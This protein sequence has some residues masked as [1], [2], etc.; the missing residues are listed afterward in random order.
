MGNSDSKLNFRKAVVQLTS[1]NQSIDLNDQQFWSQFWS[2][3]I[4][5]INDIYTLI[6]SYEIRALREESPSNLA[7]LCSKL[8]EKIQQSADGV[9]LSEKNQISILNCVRLLTRIIPYIFEDPEWRGFF[10]SEEKSQPPLGQ[11]LLD[12]LIS[13]LFVPD[14]TVHANK[15]NLNSDEGKVKTIDSCE[16]IWEAGVGFSHS[17]PQNYAHDFNRTE[18]LKL[19][20]TCF[21]ESIYLSPLIECHVQPNL[22]ITYFT[23]FKNQ[24]ALPVFTSLLNVIFSYDPVGYG[25]PYNYLMFTDSRES[26][27]EVASQL[28]C[29]LLEANISLNGDHS[30]FEEKVQNLA[31]DDPHLS[32]PSSTSTNL[33]ISY[34]SRIHRD[35]DFNFILKGFCRLLNNPMIQTF[36]PGSCKKITFFQE[37][38]I[39]FWKFC[40]LNKKFM[41]FVLKSS[42]ILDILVPVLYFLIDARADT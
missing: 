26:L 30:E 23:S 1:K 25:L 21:S 31:D 13:L 3:N 41:Y 36:L 18:I 7:S 27:V 4:P 40:D 34:I 32:S 42:E 16:Y 2:G 20:L 19:L 5:N 11:A 8:I 17:P 38:L 24:H 6:P 28:L 37:L 12:S 22:W 15:K 33:F 10:W 14:F 39:L 29:V 35:E 9:F